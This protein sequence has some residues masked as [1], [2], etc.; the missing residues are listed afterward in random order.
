MEFSLYIL[1][2]IPKFT[3]FLDINQILNIFGKIL[4]HEYNFNL[5]GRFDKKSEDQYN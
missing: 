1:I 5:N 3:T 2:L 4:L